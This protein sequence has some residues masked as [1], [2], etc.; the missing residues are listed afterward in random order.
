MDAIADTVFQG[1][2]SKTQEI[3]DTPSLLTVVVDTSI[4]SWV[5]LTK[6][7]S[8]SGSEGSSGEKQLIEALKSIVVF[9]NAHL[10]FNS[11]NQVCLIAA[12]S[13]G[14][15]YLYPS[16]DSKPS[17]SMVSSD[18]Y[19]GFRNVD[20]IVVEQWYRLFKEELEGQESKVSMK[21]SLSGAMSSALTYVNRILKENENTSL[22][23]R[24]LV[25]T[26][27]TS[28]GKDEIF[29]YIPIMNCIFSATKMKCSIDVVKIGGSIEST[30]L[31]QATDAT[32]GVYLHVENTRGLIQYLS[33]AM[34]ID[35]SLRNVIIKPN[36]GSVDF[37]T[38]CFLTG[39]VV[40][41]GFVCSVCLCVLSVIPPGQK[42]PACDSPFDS[43]IIARLRRKPVLSNG[44]PKKKNVSNK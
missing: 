16:A 41:V 26:C 28:Q 4:H 11:G 39:K 19:R 44:V 36:Q 1:T 34:F 14:M 22:R 37:R 8:G 10:A 40:A 33:T 30:F 32:S 43:K 21:S 17:M 24:L 3:E 9:L 38:S 27:G 25:I 29:Q 20:E 5:Q 15:K 7:Q 6:Q 12:H 31:Q 18:M 35:P 2:K 42:C 23:S 13:E